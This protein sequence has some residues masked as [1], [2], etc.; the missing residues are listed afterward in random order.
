VIDIFKVVR[1]KYRK[2]NHIRR[3]VT[4]ELVSPLGLLLCGLTLIQEVK[5]FVEGHIVGAKPIKHE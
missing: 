2:I 3:G 5:P 4:R 1:V